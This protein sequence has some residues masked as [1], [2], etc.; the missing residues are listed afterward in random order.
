MK[1][2]SD[3]EVLREATAVLVLKNKPLRFISWLLKVPLSTLHFHLTKRLPEIAPGKALE[4]QAVLKTHT[5][6]RKRN[7]V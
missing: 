3:R 6:G 2:Y 7:E 5:A 4:V 1:T